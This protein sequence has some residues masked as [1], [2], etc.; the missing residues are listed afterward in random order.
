MK[1]TQPI[2]IFDSGVG[3]ISVMSHIQSLL[4]NESLAYVA[5]S[6]FAPYG[7]KSKDV[8]LERSKTAID[9]LIKKQSSKLIV[10]ACNTATAAAI[11]EL[12][13]IYEIPIIG[14]EPAIKPATK[15]TICKKVGILATN[16]TLESAKFSALLET[17]SGEIDFHTQPCPGLV[18]LIEQG[19][20]NDLSINILIQKYLDP[21]IEKKVDTIVLGC[22]HYIF[23]RKLIKNQMGANVRIID[24]G[25]AV[26]KQVKSELEKFSL[27]NK[28]NEKYY[29][30]FTN[31]QNLKMEE[32]IRSMTT[33]LDFN[34]SYHSNWN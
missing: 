17:Y 25:L 23:I 22:T 13:H 2:G 12:R 5:D 16:G 7:L 21:L 30:I 8:I 27:T 4:P 33:N 29:S 3:G 14:M 31:S 9:Y 10:V 18:E 26:A 28:T 20:I 6:L 15:A 11:Q 1:N 19:K 34:Y 24:T 32:I